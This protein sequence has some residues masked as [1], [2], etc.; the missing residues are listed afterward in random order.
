MRSGGAAAQTF[1][2]GGKGGGSGD[3][4]GVAG[5][6]GQHGK[7]EHR[8]RRGMGEDG[9]PK[10]AASE[11]GEAAGGGAD[12]GRGKSPPCAAPQ[13]RDEGSSQRISKQVA[14]GGAEEMGQAARRKRLGGKDGQSQGAF[15]QVGAERGR[16][17][18]RGEQQAEE[19]DGEGGQRKR[20]G[21]E[22]EGQGNMGAEGD[23]G[24]AGEHDAG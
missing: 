15:G 5:Q 11:N 3:F 1:E 14:A 7:G 22:V 12:Q 24:A 8:L 2:A 9:Q 4:E 18:P 16:S 13:K 23:Q 10:S 21:S 19:Q 6:E 20:H 17:H